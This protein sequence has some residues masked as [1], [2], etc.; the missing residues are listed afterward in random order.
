ME[1]TLEE[2]KLA[3]TGLAHYVDDGVKFEF[4]DKLRAFIDPLEPGWCDVVR[5]MF[6]EARDEIPVLKIA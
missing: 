3:F 1:I 4:M 2:A 6:L 5:N